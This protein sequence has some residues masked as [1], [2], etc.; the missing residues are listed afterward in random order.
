MSRCQTVVVIYRRFRTVVNVNV[1][2]SRTQYANKGSTRLGDQNSAKLKVGAIDIDIPQH[3]VALHGM[4]TRGTKQLSS[5]LQVKIDLTGG[6]G[7]RFASIVIIIL[8]Q[9]LRVTRTSSRVSR[10]TTVDDM[11]PSAAGMQSSPKQST[12]TTKGSTSKQ[13][14]LTSTS[15]TAL[16][17][18]L[19]MQ[20]ETLVEVGRVDKSRVLLYISW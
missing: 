16:L 9:E 2:K 11:D 7:A 20:V 6:K 8:R 10:G 3:P 13:S 1:G 19:V 4:M 18:P 15:N 17:K 5:T 12:R 14:N